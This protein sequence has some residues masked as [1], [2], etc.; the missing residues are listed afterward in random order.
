M[1][2]NR[3]DDFGLLHACGALREHFLDRLADLGS[4]HT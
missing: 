4:R 1:Q 2:E 3:P